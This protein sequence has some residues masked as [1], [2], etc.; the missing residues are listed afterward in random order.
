M[1]ADGPDTGAPLNFPTP[2]PPEAHAPTHSAG[3]SDPVDVTDLD[4]YPNNP[5]LF[6]RG[7]GQFATPGGG[8]DVSGPGAAVTDRTIA[9]WDGTSGTMLTDT[10]VTIDGSNNL[11]TAGTVTAS[12]LDNAGDPRPP[13]AHGAT[14]ENGGGDE[15]NVDGLSGLLADPQTPLGHAATHAPGGSDPLATAAAVAVGGANAEGSATSFARA[16]HTHEVTA[17]VESSGPTALGIGGIADGEFLRRVGT[18]VV[19]AVPR[20]RSRALF[21]LQALANLDAEFKFLNIAGLLDVALSGTVGIAAQFIAP[22]PGRLGAAVRLLADVST[23]LNAGGIR[24]SVN[25]SAAATFGGGTVIGTASATSV[26]IPGGPFVFSGGDLITLELD[27]PVF[28]ARTIQAA[29]DLDLDL[30]A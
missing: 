9:V 23:T 8:G 30:A 13:T 26:A 3:G 29:L 1:S 2:E 19:G 24:I 5:S 22:G 21:G 11:A 7:D 16:D 10:G 4:G 28:G 18:E 17:V 14:H 15:I 27:F 25:G 6:L 20:S 12:N